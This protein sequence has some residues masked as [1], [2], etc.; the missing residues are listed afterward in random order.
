MWDRRKSLRPT[1][2]SPQLEKQIFRSL[3]L[4]AAAVGAPWPSFPA[5]A[6]LAPSR[7]GELEIVTAEALT[8]DDAADRSTALAAAP[9]QHTEVA[10]TSLGELIRV[11]GLRGTLRVEIHSP[12]P[13]A[14]GLRRSS[15]A[16]TGGVS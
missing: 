5:G 12:V 3:R 2:H 9:E 6:G 16:S 8:Y 11:S 4:L 10:A 14:R 1:S 7:P 13:G 15:A